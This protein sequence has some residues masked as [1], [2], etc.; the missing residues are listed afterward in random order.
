M[1]NQPHQS[2]VPSTR[3]NV[4]NN[5]KTLTL[6]SNRSVCDCDTN[7]KGTTTFSEKHISEYY[8]F[9]IS[10]FLRRR[11]IT[12]YFL[13]GHDAAGLLVQCLPDDPVRLHSWKQK[14][15]VNK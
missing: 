6:Q 5:N 12:K 9:F 13:D 7:K 8:F 15:Q 10:L 2:L 11:G 1:V 14:R 3:N 4:Y